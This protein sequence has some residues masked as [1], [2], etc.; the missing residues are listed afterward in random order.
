LKKK[1]LFN[2]KQNLNNIGQATESLL[3]ILFNIVI[4]CRTNKNEKVLKCIAKIGAII[5]I[6]K[7]RTLFHIV[8]RNLLQSMKTKNIFVEGLFDIIIALISCLEQNS[9]LLL[10]KFLTTQEL[11]FLTS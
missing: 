5:Q 10:W 8:L 3:P 9:V 2:L 4:S 11:L 6:K 7:R 1:S